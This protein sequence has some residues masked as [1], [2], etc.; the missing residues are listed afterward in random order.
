MAQKCHQTRETLIIEN[1]YHKRVTVHIVGGRVKSIAFNIPMNER[2]PLKCRK[3]TLL[4]GSLIVHDLVLNNYSH[5]H[6]KI[7]F[8]PNGYPRVELDKHHNLMISF[9]SHDYIRFEADDFRHAT[10]RG[11][12]WNTRSLLYRNKT[13][14]VPDIAYLGDQPCMMT[15]SWSYPPLDGFLDLFNHA[16]KVG[17]IPTSILYE[18]R[19]DLRAEPRFTESGLSAYLKNICSDKRTRYRYS[20]DVRR[21]IQQLLN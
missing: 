18:K 11:F 21:S 17:R 12:K 15:T 20:T 4:H 1:R 2:D 19:K 10:C 3:V 6:A 9:G 8:F 14:S 13:R 5:N 16:T 7:Y